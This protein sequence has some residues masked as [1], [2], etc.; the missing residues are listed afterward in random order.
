MCVGFHVL[1]YIWDVIFECFFKITRMPRFWQH[2]FLNFILDYWSN[3]F[4]YNETKW[5]SG[6]NI[7]SSGSITFSSFFKNGKTCSVKIISRKYWPVHVSPLYLIT[8]CNVL[9]YMF[10]LKIEFNWN[11]IFQLKLYSSIEI[12]TFNFQFSIFNLRVRVRASLCERRKLKIENWNFNW[13][14]LSNRTLLRLSSNHHKN[15]NACLISN[16]LTITFIL[17]DV[18]H[19]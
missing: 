5:I 15:P 9:A 4:C 1:Q 14:Q 6:P 11:Y 12:S 16:H 19:T 7:I 8:Q 13:I 3:M 17:F 18:R 10:N 2:F